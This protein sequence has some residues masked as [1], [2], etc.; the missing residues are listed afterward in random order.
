MRILPVVG[1]T[2]TLAVI[3]VGA[4]EVTVRAYDWAQYGVPITAPETLLSDLVVMD[5]LG[6]HARPGARYRQFR[7]NSIGARGAEQVLD[8]SPPAVVV[9]ASGASE[10][11]GLYEKPNGEWPRQLEDSMR[12]RCGAGVQVV[13]AA[14]AGMSLPTVQQDVRLR[15]SRLGAQALI[16]YPTPMQYLY[17]LLPDAAKPT[18]DG[19]PPIDP[20]RSRALPRLRDAAKRSIPEPV[21]NQLR[22]L[23]TKRSQRQ[24][25]AGA[26]NEAPTDRLDAYERD[27][28]SLVGEIRHGRMTPILMLHRNRFKDTLAIE[29]QRRLRAWERFYPLYTARA[30]IEFDAVAAERTTQVARDS[31]VPVVDPLPTLRA[32]E[33]DPFADFS[34]F[35]DLGSAVVGGVAAT[36]IAPVLC[37]GRAAVT[38]V[39]K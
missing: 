27:L 6:M 2:A 16:Y 17:P 13:N 10:T 37:A 31:L 38:P 3:I 20:W 5:S 14:F 8:T 23:D 21:L 34:H 15:L 36:A 11:F 9:I 19:P 1:W 22:I 12:V 24:A 26:R 39:K 25:G 35:N 32:L 28:R 33:A 18:T 7:I 4:F 30:I 29:E